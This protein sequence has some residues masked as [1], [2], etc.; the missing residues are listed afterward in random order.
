MTDLTWP[1]VSIPTKVN[2]DPDNFV[3]SEA[4]FKVPGLRKNLASRPKRFPLKR[5]AIPKLRLSVSDTAATMPSTITCLGTISIFSM[6]FLMMAKS[7]G[8]DIMT[9]V[10]VISSGMILTSETTPSEPAVIVEPPD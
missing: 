5:A 6:V 1:E 7:S 9:T 10:F 4:A 3:V 8:E 2:P